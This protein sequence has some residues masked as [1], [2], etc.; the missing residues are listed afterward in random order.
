M[1]TAG[2]T[3]TVPM[4]IIEEVHEYME[5]HDVSRSRVTTLAFEKFLG[6]KNTIQKKQTDKKIERLENK[7]RESENKWQKSE[8]ELTQTLM[9]MIDLE[10]K[11][12][13]LHTQKKQDA[14]ENKELIIE[15]NRAVRQLKSIKKKLLKLGE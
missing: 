9:Y 10:D 5:K 7:L 3:V 14:S 15:K 12:K 8:D 13:E 4:D 11:A 1:G 6:S 2:F